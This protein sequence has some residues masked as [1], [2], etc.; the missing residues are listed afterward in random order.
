MVNGI[1]VVLLL[2]RLSDFTHHKQYKYDSIKVQHNIN[3][4]KYTNIKNH[5][6]VMLIQGAA[7]P[8]QTACLR[9]TA[10]PSTAPQIQST[11]PPAPPLSSSWQHVPPHLHAAVWT[12]S[13]PGHVRV[14]STAVPG[15]G[16]TPVVVCVCCNMI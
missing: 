5:I 1:D 6:I 2:F 9:P 13:V 15:C 16:E 11:T 4:I 8:L 3:N 10:A 12:K 14:A 7:R